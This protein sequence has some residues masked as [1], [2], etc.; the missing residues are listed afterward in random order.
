MQHVLT[1]SF[2]VAVLL[3]LLAACQGRAGAVVPRYTPAEQTIA[4]GTQHT[5]SF[6]SESVGA[7]P[8][9]AEA[10]SGSW[11]V[12]AENGAPSAPNALCQTAN[13]RWPVL[14]LDNDVYTDLD[15]STR[16]KPISGREDQAA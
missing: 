1:G 16:F 12:R 15:F 10:V 13:T 5:W 4:A 7:L 2:L 3:S 14:L 11:A 6:D 8:T 9:G